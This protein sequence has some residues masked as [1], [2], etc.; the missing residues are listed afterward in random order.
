MNTTEMAIIIQK[1]LVK[2]GNALK[3]DGIIGPKTEAVIRAVIG[4][5]NVGKSDIAWSGKL[6]KP[7]L[8]AVV[9]MSARLGVNPSYITTIM[10]LETG[11]RF[12]SDVINAAGS[13]ATG[14]IQFMP[15]TAKA[16][17]TSTELLAKMTPIEQLVYVEKYFKPYTGAM[18]RLVDCYLAVLYPDAMGGA[19]DDVIWSKTSTTSFLRKCYSQNIGFDK[20]KKGF[21]TVRD[22]ADTIQKVMDE[23]MSKTA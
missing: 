13:G 7:F 3:V 19:M 14:L 20:T 23:G 5:D 12:T 22:V 1:L 6:T 8:D 10:A 4:D 16:L 21:I 2:M 9:D 15:S 11:R 17:G 18:D